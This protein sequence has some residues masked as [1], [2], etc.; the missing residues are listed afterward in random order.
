MKRHNIDDYLGEE[1]KE[2]PDWMVHMV[3][4]ESCDY[5]E[6]KDVSKLHKH[7]CNIH[8]HGLEKYDSLELQ[9]VLKLPTN[10]IGYLINTVGLAIRY[11]MKL[12]DGDEINHLIKNFVIKVKE[13]EDD[14][15]VKV[16]RLILPDASGK[17][18]EDEECI[19]PYSLQYYP[20]SVIYNGLN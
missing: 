1:C 16:L 12:H 4:M 3:L 14:D 19:E 17:F 6:Q 5:C 7:M 13:I 10:L 9:L 18:P 8:T 2:K 11:G 15:E 20:T